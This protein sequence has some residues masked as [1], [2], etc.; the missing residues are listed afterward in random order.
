MVLTRESI[1]S[2]YTV[3][4]PVRLLFA[5]SSFA[6]STGIRSDTV[7]CTPLRRACGA[8]CIRLR[9]KKH[10]LAMFEQKM[11]KY[12]ENVHRLFGYCSAL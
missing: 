7:F 2:V 3:V 9:Q 8:S 6:Q 12:R 1:P 5:T 11:G 10:F 4:I